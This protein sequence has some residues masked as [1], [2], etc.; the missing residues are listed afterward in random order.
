MQLLSVGRR[1]AVM[2]ALTALTIAAPAAAEPQPIGPYAPYARAGDLIFLSGQIAID[3]ANGKLDTSLPIEDQTRLVWR[4][5]E[6]VLE[7]AGLDLGAVVQATVYLT[8]IDDFERMNTA[9]ALALGE[10]R[11]ARTTIGVSALPLGAKIEI[12]VVASLRAAGD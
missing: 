5:I 7:G 8:D 9:Y 12:A 10:I 6:T 4:N 1:V 3:P 2:L 11:P